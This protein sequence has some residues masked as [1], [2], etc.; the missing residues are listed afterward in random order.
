MKKNRIAAGVRVKLSE[1]WFEKSLG[2][3]YLAEEPVIF[4]ADGHIYNDVKG[5]YVFLKGGSG[6]TSGVA[7]L[8][9][10]EP[11][12]PMPEGCLYPYNSDGNG[13]IDGAV[14]Y[15]I[16]EIDRLENEV[17]KLSPMALVEDALKKLEE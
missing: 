13:W 3:R 2:D 1:I 9:E 14:K 15:L 7:Y 16:S 5:E 17:V 4:I 12:F 6:T 8:N 10:I 11:E